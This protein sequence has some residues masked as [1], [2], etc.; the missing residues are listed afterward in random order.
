MEKITITIDLNKIDKNRIQERIYQKDG[1]WVTVREYKMEV[2]P[3][4]TRKIIKQGDKWQLLKSH[5]VC[6]SQTKDERDERE[7]RAG[8]S[9]LGEGVM[10]ANTDT[11]TAK[12]EYPSENIKPEYVP[13]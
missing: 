1:V 13:F 6:D 12:K 8:T 9:F 7:A 3:L 2:V 5:F 10:F 11:Q 4:K